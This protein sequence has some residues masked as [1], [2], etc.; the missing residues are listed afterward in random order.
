[1][2]IF[3]SQPAM[4]R[5]FKIALCV[6]LA[7]PGLLLLLALVPRKFPRS[8]LIQ[9]VFLGYTNSPPGVTYA[10]F[11]LTNL[12]NR[13]VKFWPGCQIDLEDRRVPLISTLRFAGG[14][15]GSGQGMVF[16][17]GIPPV[18]TRWQAHWGVTWDSLYEQLLDLRDRWHVPFHL[19]VEGHENFGVVSDWFPP[20]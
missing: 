7:L 11:G 5:P 15:L 13:P 12:A 6:A 20:P 8:P 16:V 4:R 14:R 17:V 10:I 19:E 3:R 9:A 18:T 1:M 2:R